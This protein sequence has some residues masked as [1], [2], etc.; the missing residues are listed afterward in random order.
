MTMASSSFSPTTYTRNLAVLV[1]EGWEGGKTPSFLWHQWD[2]RPVV[3][4]TW[5]VILDLSFSV[6][7]WTFALLFISTPLLLYVLETKH[8]ANFFH[9]HFFIILWAAQFKFHFYLKQC[10][11]QDLDDW[12]PILRLSWWPS[13]WPCLEN[14]PFTLLNTLLECW[15]WWVCSVTRL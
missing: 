2:T 4:P 9:W 7:F 13:F 1:E 14:L 10:T 5:R 15:W 6:L 11:F 8:W 3:I 12:Q